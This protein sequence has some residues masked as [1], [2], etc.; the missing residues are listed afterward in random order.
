MVAPITSTASIEEDQR[1]SDHRKRSPSCFSPL[2]SRA[3]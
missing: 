1:I 3:W 2:L